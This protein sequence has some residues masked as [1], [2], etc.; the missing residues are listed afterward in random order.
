MFLFSLD[1]IILGIVQG[2]TEFLPI[3]SSGHLVLLENLFKLK[4]GFDF[5]VLM[6]GASFLAILIYFRKDFL[7]LLKNKKL[8]LSLFLAMLPIVIIGFVFKDRISLINSL[9]FTGICFLLTSLVLFLTYF[10]KNKAQKSLGNLGIIDCLIIGLFQAL[11]VLPGVS[12][13]GMTISA[14]MYRGFSQK[15]SFKFSFLLGGIALF[16]AMVL[17]FEQISALS[18]SF[19]NILAF[20]L[21][22]IFSLLSLK[23]LS[24][25]LSSGK[26][27]YFSFYCFILGLFCLYLAA[28]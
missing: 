14:G 3:S 2:I 16:G 11:A 24:K 21:A 13:S 8:V 15:D 4:S 7:S 5:N 23:V 18:L 6:H 25:I 1:K 19:S 17:D 12:R 28:K 26:F 9:F 20:I 22:F 27:Y 10:F